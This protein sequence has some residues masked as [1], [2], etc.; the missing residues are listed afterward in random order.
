MRGATYGGFLAYNGPIGFYYCYNGYLGTL[1]PWDYAD[2]GCQVAFQV[3][4][5]RRAVSPSAVVEKRALSV[6]Y[7]GIKGALLIPMHP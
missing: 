1:V 7:S 5:F 6:I 3:T 2:I 4:N